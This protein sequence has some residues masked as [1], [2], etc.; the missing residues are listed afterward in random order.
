MD[1]TNEDSIE[2]EP[3]TTLGGTVKV[4]EKEVS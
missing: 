2:I 1:K 4:T 3:N